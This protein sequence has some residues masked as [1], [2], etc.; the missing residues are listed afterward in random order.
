MDGIDILTY[1]DDTIAAEMRLTEAV[2][3]KILSPFWLS[4]ADPNVI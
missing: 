1:F 3:Q 2:N 4:Q